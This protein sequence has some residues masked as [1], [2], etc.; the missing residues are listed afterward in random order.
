MIVFC[1]ECGTRHVIESDKIDSNGHQFPCHTCQEILIVTSSGKLVKNAQAAMCRPGGA[2][3]PQ[4]SVKLRVLI[5][6]DSKLI[7]K[8]LK[9]IIESD[10]RKEVVGE[11][12]N[13][14]A[15][16]E[17]LPKVAPD[18]I[19]LD[20]NMPVMD[21]LT[22]L[23]HIMIVR[24]TPTVMISAL[25]K[26]GSLETFDSLKY[27]AID[28]LPKPSQVKGAD[29]KAQQNE[30]LSKI[31]LASAVQIESVRYLRRLSQKDKPRKDGPA[32]CRFLMAIGVAEGG[33]GAL[34]NVLPGL[35]SDLPAAYVAI[36]RQPAVHI[37]SFAEYLSRCSHLEV[38]RVSD[39]VEIRGGICYLAAANEYV[40][41]SKSGSRIVMQ[42]KAA[43]ASAQN[44]PIDFLM[45]SVAEIMQDH[46]GGIILTGAGQDGIQG[47][48]QVILHGGAS[49]VQ[50]PI[51]CLYKETP[52]NAINSHTV[53]HLV[54][55]KQMAGA[56]NSYLVS[57][58][59]Q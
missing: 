16:L 25:T 15:A 5:V 9:E 36:M 48:G 24:P 30:I 14:K 47:L 7:R 56:I 40:K 18:V 39:G 33:Y 45:N 43:T 50:D 28:F 26:E 6:D 2:A 49:F 53:N 54:S 31:E 57:H 1:E 10:G 59:N 55:D 13:G 20:I 8:V 44:G 29:L 52:L 51:S 46:A 22:T 19:T 3:D 32:E 38:K 12:E 17:L 4:T 27:G 37:D 41:V 58:S 35:R 11:A 42:V 21:G 34:L 23:K